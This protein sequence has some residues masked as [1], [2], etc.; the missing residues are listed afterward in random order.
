MTTQNDNIWH[1]AYKIPWDDPEFSRRMLAVHLA[2]DSDLASRPVKW[3]DKQV[4]WIH[5]Q[6]LGKRPSS[7]LDLGCGP[8]FYLHRLATLGHH[9]RGIDFGPASIEYARRHNPDASRCEFILGDIRKVAFGG[10]YDLAMILYGEF[11][12]FSPTEVSA[13]LRAIEGS[14]APH[15]RV[16][17]EVQTPNAVE[18]VGRGKPSEQQC[19]SGLFSDRPYRCHT[20]NQWLPGQK[21]AIQSFS[22]TDEADGQTREYRSTTKAWPDD[23]LINL[24]TRASLRGVERCKDWPVST[25]ALALWIARKN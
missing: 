22:V 5:D 6:L 7:I 4:A 3:I 1:R 17:L 21:I 20:K 9:C 18:T 13:I 19:E 24:L 15:G 25:D 2:Q 12:V 8:G 10:P 11:N 14:L 16:I 23:E